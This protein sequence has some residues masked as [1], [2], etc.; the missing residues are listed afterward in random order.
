MSPLPKSRSHAAGGGAETAD[1]AI[2]FQF[3]SRIVSGLHPALAGWDDVCIPTTVES[4]GAAVVAEP[5]PTCGRRTVRKKVPFLLLGASPRL[6][7]KR[8][9]TSVCRPSRARCMNRCTVTMMVDSLRVSGGSCLLRCL[10]GVAG[11]G[12]GGGVAAAQVAGAA[13]TRSHRLCSSPSSW[14]GRRKQWCMS[15]QPEYQ[16]EAPWSCRWNIRAQR[17]LPAAIR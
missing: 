4:Q 8:S 12:C 10:L 5:R 17:Q 1:P 2:C 7:H 3:V 13:E 6:S 14:L 15:G 9:M 16:L 11:V